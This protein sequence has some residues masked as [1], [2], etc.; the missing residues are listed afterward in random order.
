MTVLQNAAENPTVCDAVFTFKDEDA[1][2]IPGVN[3]GAGAGGG[4]GLVA[5]L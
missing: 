1:G 3:G 5:R 4:G 2:S